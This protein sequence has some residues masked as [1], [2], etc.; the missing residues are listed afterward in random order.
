MWWRGAANYGPHKEALDRSEGDGEGYAW[1]GVS[2]FH[3]WND[4]IRASTKVTDITQRSVI[5]PTYTKC[6]VLL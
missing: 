1:N 2:L 5:V 4:E 6:D 3:I